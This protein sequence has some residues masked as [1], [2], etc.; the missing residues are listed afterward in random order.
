MSLKA[1]QNPHAV[2]NLLKQWINSPG[3]G[4]PSCHFSRR[5]EA[6]PKGQPAPKSTHFLLSGGAYVID[7]DMNDEFLWRLAIALNQG[8]TSTIVETRTDFF[9]Y[10]IDF[11]FNQKDVVELHTVRDYVTLLQVVLR[12]FFPLASNVYFE[13]L[14]ST[15]PTK[16]VKAVDGETELIK[17]G[18]HVIYPH[19]W[20]HKD[21]ALAVRAD[22]ITHLEREFP[23]RSLPLYNHWNDVVDESVY[24]GS[25]LRMLSCIKAHACPNK[26]C[27]PRYQYGKNKKVPPPPKIPGLRKP[28]TTAVENGGQDKAAAP[29][30]SDPVDLRKT[31]TSSTAAAITKQ[32]DTVDPVPAVPPPALQ[33]PEPPCG[34]CQ[35]GYIFEGRPYFLVAAWDFKADTITRKVKVPD[36]PS[37]DTPVLEMTHTRMFEPLP[38]TAGGSGP[39]CFPAMPMPQWTPE[40]DDDDDLNLLGDDDDDDDDG[41]G[42]PLPDLLYFGDPFSVDPP[43]NSVDAWKIVRQVHNSLRITSIRMPA[44]LLEAMREVFQADD[45]DYLLMSSDLSRDRAAAV[46]QVCPR[47]VRPAGATPFARA[48]AA[49]ARHSKGQRFYDHKGRPVES[50]SEVRICESVTRGHKAYVTDVELLNEIEQFIRHNVGVRGEE[51]IRPYAEIEVC[52]VIFNATT[53]HP[54]SYLVS[55]RGFGSGYCMNRG[56]DHKSNNIY[57]TITKAGLVQRCHCRCNTIEHRV[58]GRC[59]DFKSRAFDLPPRI[60]EKLFTDKSGSASSAG[61]GAGDMYYG[62]GLAL[63]NIQEPVQESVKRFDVQSILQHMPTTLPEGCDD[64]DSFRA[65]KR[66][67]EEHEL[68]LVDPEKRIKAIN[69]AE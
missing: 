19:L 29:T 28:S 13:C 65:K 60:K 61:L 53:K 51:G 40:N 42:V 11:D 67:R 6:T 63:E 37:V 8:F 57:F 30:K 18:Y 26:T 45:G 44:M 43:R 5:R 24:L 36:Q 25:G 7:S 12:K 4:R 39:V 14:V 21:Q 41:G 49:L 56:D 1:V 10:F 3:Q 47:F 33:V 27:A 2:V 55:V 58:A 59:R 20:M 68:G 34:K 38:D 69:R 35:K 17:S 50:A 15:A 23:E 62:G 9:K 52:D 22:F 64:F 16:K 66:E 32:S 31:L 46:H 48:S 54:L